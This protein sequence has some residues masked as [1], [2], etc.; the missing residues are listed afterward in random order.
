MFLYIILGYDVDIS[1]HHLAPNIQEHMPNGNQI[2][3][4]PPEEIKR[5]RYQEGFQRNSNEYGANLKTN[6]NGNELENVVKFMKE[7]DEDIIDLRRHAV[8]PLSRK[9]YFEKSQVGKCLLFVCCKFVNYKTNRY[10]VIQAALE[11]K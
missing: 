11:N 8:T 9:D 1:N 6:D 3:L 10:L 2:L 5:H 4:P 7:E